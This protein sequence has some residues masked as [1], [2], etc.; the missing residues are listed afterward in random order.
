MHY[1][2]DDDSTEGHLS[3]DFPRDDDILAVGRWVL[4]PNWGRGQV[5]AREGMDADTKLT[6]RFSRGQV[7]KVVVAYASLE[8]A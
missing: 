8:P 2:F 4:H 7:K 6:I 1:E 5:V 3:D